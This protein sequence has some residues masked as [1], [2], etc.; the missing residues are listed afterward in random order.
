M[1]YSCGYLRRIR[2]PLRGQVNKTDYI[3]KKLALEKGMDLDGLRL[4]LPANQAAKEYG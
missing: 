1:N 4:G 3:L 2:H